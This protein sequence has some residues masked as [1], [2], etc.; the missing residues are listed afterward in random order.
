M[1]VIGTLLYR[2]IDII[3]LLICQLNPFTTSIAL[4]NY[5]SHAEAV[6]AVTQVKR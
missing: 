4:P 5:T 6:N 1:S 2:H 3:K